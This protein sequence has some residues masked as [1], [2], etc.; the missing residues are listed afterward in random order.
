[1]TINGFQES[2]ASHRRERISDGIAGADPTDHH[3][4][5]SLGELLKN[6]RQ[7][8]AL[9]LRQASAKIDGR[10]SPAALGSYERGQRA[11]SVLRLI[12]LA[13]LYGVD[14]GD[15]M[16]QARS[17]SLRQLAGTTSADTAVVLTITATTMPAEARRTPLGR[18]LIL[19]GAQSV[20][21]TAE[22]IR[23]LALLH[24]ISPDEFIRWVTGWEPHPARWQPRRAS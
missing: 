7:A 1:V 2:D 15:L 21:L 24:R 10:F 18:Y 17:R 13:E 12:T 19:H 11:I 20:D 4:R 9:T 3:F 23:S 14:A 6:A 16:I 22:Q 8:R 5:V